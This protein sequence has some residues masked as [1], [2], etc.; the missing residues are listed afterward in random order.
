MQRRTPMN[1]IR[2]NTVPPMRRRLTTLIGL[3]FALL[4]VGL[5]SHGASAA[6]ANTDTKLTQHE[7]VGACKGADGV[8]SRGGPRQ[9]KCDFGGGNSITCN[10]K[11]RECIETYSQAA[12]PRSLSLDGV[13]GPQSD[14][15][16]DPNNANPT[17][18][19]AAAFSFTPI[20]NR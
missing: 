14:K 17:Q 12:E 19:P 6:T 5:S 1:Q 10:F 13:S 16:L 3:T 18:T 11:T 7:W 15:S 8:P 4:I 2:A 9:V 20:E